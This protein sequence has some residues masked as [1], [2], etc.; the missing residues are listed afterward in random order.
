MSKKVSASAGGKNQVAAVTSDE[1]D[2]FGAERN[3]LAV[4][5]CF[6][7]NTQSV[8]EAA[9]SD[10]EH[11]YH[12]PSVAP[13]TG[14]GQA[15]PAAGT[16][17]PGSASIPSVPQSES[18]S[19]SSSA[20][21]ASSTS[22]TKSSKKTVTTTT[23]TSRVRRTTS[24]AAFDAGNYFRAIGSSFRGNVTFTDPWTKKKVLLPHDSASPNY[25]S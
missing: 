25:D 14:T 9:P 23:T 1:D 21:S 24:A 6:P 7:I 11:I 15:T 20:S 12:Q 4:P 10:F 16:S 18:K 17:I 5:G 8:M 19:S 3:A 22:R 2:Q 13:T